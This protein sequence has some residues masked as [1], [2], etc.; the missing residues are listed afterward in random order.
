[1]RLN[2]A[3]T[4]QTAAWRS[5]QA[6]YLGTVVPAATK[7]CQGGT[8]KPPI[9]HLCPNYS[10]FILYAIIVHDG[11]N[12][13]HPILMRYRGQHIR[14]GSLVP[15]VNHLTIS[16]VLDGCTFSTVTLP[17]MG[18]NDDCEVFY[19]L[20]IA[21][22]NWRNRLAVKH[23]KSLRL[24]ICSLL[25]RRKPRRAHP[26][27]FQLSRWYI[28]QC[29]SIEAIPPHCLTHQC[30]TPFVAVHNPGICPHISLVIGYHSHFCRATS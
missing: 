21:L 29:S 19:G 13:I 30:R 26:A 1:M 25:P 7:W 6:I 2:S 4:P 16:G 11:T 10:A 20:F 24:Q 18:S 8:A 14:L 22:S 27:Q 5:L 28:A 23:Q 3:R 9:E 17:I 12:S 15:C